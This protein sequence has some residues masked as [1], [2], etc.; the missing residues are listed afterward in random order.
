MACRPD[1][2]Q[3]AAPEMFGESLGAMLGV[4]ISPCFNV[5]MTPLPFTIDFTVDGLQRDHP[6]TRGRAD[7]QLHGIRTPS[8]GID[9]AV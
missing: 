6:G 8:L 2:W 5:R 3:L 9:Y 1:G 4:P 7:E